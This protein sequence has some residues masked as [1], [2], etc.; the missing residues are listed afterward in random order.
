[1]DWR[2]WREWRMK[3]MVLVRK[4]SVLCDWMHGK[5]KKGVASVVSVTVTS[6]AAFLGSTQGP[7]MSSVTFYVRYST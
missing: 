1:M 5:A 3:L 7:C 2:E 6:A 4:Y